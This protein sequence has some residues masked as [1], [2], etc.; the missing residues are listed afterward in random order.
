MPARTRNSLSIDAD[1]WPDKKLQGID[2]MDQIDKHNAS[3]GSSPPSVW[4]SE[5]R[6]R[7]ERCP[8]STHAEHTPNGARCNR[9]FRGCNPWIQA[10]MVTDEDT[11]TQGASMFQQSGP[12][13]SISA[14]WFLNEKMDPRARQFHVD[15]YVRVTE[16]TSIGLESEPLLPLE[17][18][19][20]GKLSI[21]ISTKY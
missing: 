6:G 5:V 3:I 10:A 15:G 8:S 18:Q 4:R 21:R 1:N 7:F 16:N 11:N 13:W 9:C 20:A 12:A 17:L 2:F 19:I 14:G